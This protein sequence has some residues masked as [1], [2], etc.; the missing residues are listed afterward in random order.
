MQPKPDDYTFDLEAALSA[1]VGV[2]SIIP[3][4]AFTAATLGTERTG[5]GVLIRPDGLVLTVG[6][7]INEA[8]TVWL[9]LSNGNAVQGHVIVYD[10]ITGLGLVQA[11]AREE[12]PV[13]A[14]GTSAAAQVG[15]D[16]V[17]GGAGGL[18]N[19]LAARIVSRQEF[20][21]YWEYLIEDA[22]FAAPSHENW[23]GTALINEAGQLIGVGSL[24][25]EHGV[26]DGPSEHINMFIPI[27]LL[28]PVFDDLV[29]LGRRTTPP[30]PWLGVYAAE[31]GG[32]VVVA[33]FAG[34]GPAAKSELKTGDILLQI[35]GRE[36]KSLSE[37]FHSLWGLGQAGVDVPLLVHRDGRTFDLKIR[38]ADRATMM[39][40][41][42]LH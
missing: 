31:M 1:M 34:R 8:E 42:I 40:R 21:G 2:R 33:G 7:L 32:R 5:N 26:E 19:S 35:G 12:F 23:G 28:P 15:D 22:I 29:N 38:S 16:V 30:R 27:D 25:L 13:L 14:M 10:H 4:D 6:Y 20:A 3:Q 18:Q 11:L 37:F 24:Q 36:A 41:P 17:I 9:S 39:K